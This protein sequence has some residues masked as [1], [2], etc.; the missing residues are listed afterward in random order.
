MISRWQRVCLQNMYN[1]H[2]VSWT[3]SLRLGHPLIVV[4][5][6]SGQQS[7]IEE[8]LKML[9]ADLKREQ[10]EDEAHRKLVAAAQTKEKPP[11]RL[12]IVEELKHYY[13]GFRLLALETKISA[14]Y[15]WRIGRGATLSRRERKQLI[16][17]VSDL[18]RLVPFS[19][20]VIVPF[21][22]LA[23][24][25]FIKLFPNML[26][27][28][29]QEASKEE[30][31]HRKQLLVKVEMAK[32]L[33]STI[34]EIAHQRKSNE[35]GR[36]KALEFSEF[37]SKLRSEG[38]YV[39]N[40]DLFKYT[41][42]FE[43]ELTL[44]NLSMSQLRALCHVLSIQPLGT[45]EILQFQLKLKLRELQADDRQIVAEGGIEN[46]TNTELQQAARARGMRAIGVSEERLRAQ[47]QQ[48]LDLSMDDKIPPSLLLLTRILYLSD[49]VPFA[50]RLKYLISKLPEGVAEQTRQKLHDVDLGDADYKTRLDFIRTIEKAIAAEKK[51][52]EVADKKDGKSEDGGR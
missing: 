19:I 32:F 45:P 21:M 35:Q 38:R 1:W 5:H 44:D 25:L 9:K 3:P 16:R 50:Q 41:Q 14:K 52:K 29:F 34:E 31:K 23:L 26:P 24:P 12:R 42:L 27:S 40:E 33:R 39:S 15:V 49:E 10:E 2:R 4:R 48:W 11:L 47:L 18:F 7:K 13:N 30:E 28:T 36:S 46:L 8:T 51:S 37:M 43:D 20:F 6:S 17:T 22:E